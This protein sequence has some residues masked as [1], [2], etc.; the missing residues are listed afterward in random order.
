MAASKIDPANIPGSCH[1]G[2]EGVRRYAAGSC[3]LRHLQHLHTL[4][5]L[6]TL[7]SLIAT[8]LLIF[9]ARPPP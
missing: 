3:E 2:Y 7:Q 1:N 6:R 9:R 5:H 4:Q 8:S